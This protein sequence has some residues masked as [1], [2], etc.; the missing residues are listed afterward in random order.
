MPLREDTS[1]ETRNP[2][3]T[4]PATFDRLSQEEYIV[5]ENKRKIP[6]LVK[7]GI[8]DDV[9]SYLENCSSSHHVPVRHLQF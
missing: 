3:D 4:L 9:S 1:S 7:F 6:V 5:L 8:S 2:N